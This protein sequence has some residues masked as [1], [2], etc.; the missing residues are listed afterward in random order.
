MTELNYC[1]MAIASSHKIKFEI[2]I[3]QLPASTQHGV[4]DMFFNLYLVKILKIAQNSTTNKAKE[5]LGTILVL[6]SLD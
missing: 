5:K 3:D 2:S 4:S 1:S 6:E